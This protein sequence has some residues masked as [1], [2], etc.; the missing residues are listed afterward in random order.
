MRELDESRSIVA[1][2]QQRLDDSER[3]A[4]Q[5]QELLAKINEL[6]L[7]RESNSTLRNENARL[8]K[9]TAATENGLQKIQN[10]VKPLEGIKSFAMKGP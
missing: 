3:L 4:S 7:L 2:S 8:L 6:N 1:N 10:L 9:K 5:H